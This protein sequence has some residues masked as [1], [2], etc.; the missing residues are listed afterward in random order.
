MPI[1]SK[2]SG[3]MHTNGGIKLNINKAKNPVNPNA[4]KRPSNKGQIK[5]KRFLGKI[6]D[7]KNY[8]KSQ[9]KL[10]VAKE[11]AKSFKI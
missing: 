8:F 3:R 6:S 9:K 4:S 2:K 5:L 10:I 7:L 1:K 11:I